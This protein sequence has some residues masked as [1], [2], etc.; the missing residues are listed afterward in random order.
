MGPGP[1]S[2]TTSPRRTPLI[3]STGWTAAAKGSHS[4]ASSRPM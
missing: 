4:A 3:S 2:R 1:E